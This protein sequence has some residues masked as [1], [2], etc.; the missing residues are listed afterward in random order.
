MRTDQFRALTDGEFSDI[1]CCAFFL[2]PSCRPGVVLN[3]IRALDFQDPRKA[4][5]CREFV[6]T[7][8][9]VGWWAD[10]CRGWR[11]PDLEGSFVE[12]WV[13]L[14]GWNAVSRM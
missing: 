12:L 3:I 2:F 11:V 8:S 5:H 13:R 4:G 10:L 7:A 9:V 6:I 14:G 1:S